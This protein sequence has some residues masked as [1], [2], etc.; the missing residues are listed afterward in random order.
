ME[1][2]GASRFVRV[3]YSSHIVYNTVGIVSKP[4]TILRFGRERRREERGGNYPLPL[5]T[6]VGGSTFFFFSLQI[7]MAASHIDFLKGQ[8]QGR[9]CAA[10]TCAIERRAPRFSM[11][12]VFERS[13]AQEDAAGNHSHTTARTSP[14]GTTA[15]ETGPGCGKLRCLLAIVYVAGTWSTFETMR[16]QLRTPAVKGRLQDWRMEKPCKKAMTRHRHNT[17]R[18]MHVRLRDRWSQFCP[19]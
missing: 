15:Y 7:A 8:D 13:C 9:P 19:C 18:S 4:Q 12:F 11:F 16:R 6:D 2:L 10:R 5:K 14:A 3:I 1:D 17:L